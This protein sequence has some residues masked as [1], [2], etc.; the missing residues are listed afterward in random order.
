V[1]PPA[2]SAPVLACAGFEKADGGGCDRLCPKV[3]VA[4]GENPPP[5]GIVQPA[6]RLLLVG[7]RG[8]AGLLDD[9]WA[10]DEQAT[11]T[12]TDPAQAGDG[13]W[14]SGWRPLGTLPDTGGGLVSPGVAQVRDELHLFGGLTPGGPTNALWR[15]SLADG[16]AARITPAGP[17]PAPRVSPALAFDVPGNRLL[18]FGGTDA[19]GNGL[20]DLWGVPLGGGE[21]KRLAGSCSGNG[22]PVVTGRETLY[23]HPA[24]RTVTVIADR[25]GPAASE[26]SWTLESGVWRTQR[27]RQAP[28]GSI[29]CDGDGVPERL[30]GLRCSTGTGGFPDFGRLSCGPEGRPACRPPVA[31]GGI[32]ARE[33]LHP[34][35]RGMASWEGRLLVLH[36]RT[37]EVR[38]ISPAGAVSLERRIGIDRPGNDLAVAGDLLLVADERG[39]AVHRLPEGTRA[40]RVDTCGPAQRVFADGARAYVVASRSIL[41]VDLRD[42]AAPVVTDRVR[43]RPLRDR[44]ELAVEAPAAA[45]SWVGRGLDLLSSW[46]T[47]CGASGR[48]VA[49]YD[50]GRIYLHALGLFYVIDFRGPDP[51][52]RAALTVGPVSGIEAE[53]G[54]VY[55]NRVGNRT[56]VVAE[57]ATGVWGLVGEHDVRE[58]VD[59][60]T[61][62]GAWAVRWDRGELRVAERQ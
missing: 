10:Y 23:Y 21:W 45:C 61:E 60:V 13:P 8:E 18:V 42:P 11:M 43:V 5:D 55:L 54:F 48:A 17:T 44:L 53:A 32:A 6:G 39:L 34:P 15:I 33:R 30:V 29:D 26:M 4:L 19:A 12:R 22:C 62:C 46:F 57:I 38:A 20:T 31:P 56:A 37:V 41:A 50:E 25:G 51:I 2:R 14:P 40:G 9:I 3:G 35:P 28:A 36:D 24:E 1:W 27:E 16:R 59:G 47:P 7:G 49:A 52:A 58:W